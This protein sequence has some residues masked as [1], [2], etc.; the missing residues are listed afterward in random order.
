LHQSGGRIAIDPQKI[1]DGDVA[2]EILL[3]IGDFVMLREK[4]TSLT[5]NARAQLTS[6]LRIDD[7]GWEVVADGFRNPQGLAFA[8]LDGLG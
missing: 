6:V 7:S 2:S 4:S 3:S 5:Q 8:K 1:S